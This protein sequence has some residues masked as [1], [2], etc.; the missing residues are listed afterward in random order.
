MYCDN[1]ELYASYLP[2]PYLQRRT[3]HLPLHLHLHIHFLPTSFLGLFH[4]L[5]RDLF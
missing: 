1:D 4:F 3:P 5:L 2:F